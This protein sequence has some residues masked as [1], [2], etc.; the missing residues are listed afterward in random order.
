MKLLKKIND[1][2]KEYIMVKT[3]MGFTEDEI[4]AELGC[5]QANINRYKVRINKDLRIVQ[6]KAGK[7]DKPI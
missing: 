1:P 2:V 5:S 7:Y 6:G 4:A 3:S